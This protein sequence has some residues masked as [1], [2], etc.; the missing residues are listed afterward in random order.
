MRIA[1]MRAPFVLFFFFLTTTLSAENVRFDP[2]NP[3]SETPVV[4][5][6]IGEFATCAPKSASVTRNGSIISI[7]IDPPNCPLTT[8]L[9]IVGFDL[10][11]KLGTLSPGVYQVVAAVGNLLAG[12]GTLIVQDANPPFE[13]TPNVLAFGGGDVVVITGHDL[14]HCTAGI[15]PPVCETPIVK[16]GDTTASLASA[17]PEQ[18]VVHLG[19][20][21]APGPV[22]VTIDR[23]GNLLRTTAA[24]YFAPSD[25]PPDA[26][27]YEALLFPVS[28]S[29][30]QPG[31]F[32]SQWITQIYLRNENDYGLDL[33]PRAIFNLGCFFECNDQ[34]EKHTTRTTGSNAPHG[35]SAFIPRQAARYVH[36]SIVARDL[37]REAEAAGAEIPVVREKDLFDRPLELLNVPTDRRFRVSVRIYDVA[38]AS[39]VRMTISPLSR[40]EVLV[41][42]MPQLS[43]TTPGYF[44]ISDLVA[45]YPQ[46]VGKGPLRIKVEPLSVGGPRTLWA[47]ASITNNETQHVTTISPQ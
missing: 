7:K 27:F 47:F 6:V 23:N 12:D 39:L 17:T 2:P 36:V 14:I 8:D 18:I 3:T 22:D 31:A 26:A 37:S 28:Y 5:H 35:F 21:H 29:A 32:G 43:A 46:L 44:Q 13:V 40:E 33:W 41:S 30:V 1:R 38:S 9:V 20:L 19:N 24:F 4:A 11:V 10:P 45:T 42:T 34:I 15:T 25:K 16:F